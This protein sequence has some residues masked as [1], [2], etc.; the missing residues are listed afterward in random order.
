MSASPGDEREPGHE[1]DPGDEREPATSAT[2][3]D[4]LDPA[5]ADPPPRAPGPDAT[6]RTPSGPVLRVRTP[7]RTFVATGLIVVNVAVYLAMTLA[8]ASAGSPGAVDL[9]AWGANSGE[10]V[11]AGEVWRL[12]TSMFV[13]AGIAHIALNMLA[14]RSLSIVEGLYGNAAF[15]ALYLLAGLGGSIASLLVN[16]IKASVGASGAVFGVAGALLAFFLLHRRAMPRAVFR[17]TTGSLL[18]MLG[19][20]VAFGFSIPQVDNAAHLGGLAVGFLSGLALDRE[21]HAR[22][23]LGAKRLVR[24]LG[25]ALAL[26]ALGLLIPGRVEAGLAAFE[27]KLVRD[28]EAAFEEGDWEELLAISRFVISNESALA[29]SDSG[30]A[31]DGEGGD[32]VG[33]REALVL[34]W[35]ARARLGES[36]AVARETRELRATLGADDAGSD[37]GLAT[38]L[39]A[40][41]LDPRDYRDAA[42][43]G[44]EDPAERAWGEFVLAAAHELAGR[45]DDARAAYEQA[46][47]APSSLGGSLARIEL[48]RRRD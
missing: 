9:V 32:G 13:H 33:M 28:V 46:A 14:L 42:I 8:G 34:R 10:L 12:L 30:A 43:A 1:R 38:A 7:A 39:F 44:A 29:R 24:A 23:R 36:A 48:G 27:T 6:V 31:E 2:P 15:L 16:P 17:R 25:I 26:A 20:N 5:R 11:A 4:G 40:G 21:A 41:E 19:I 22:P 47:A 35:I 18:L 3:P 45:A 37:I